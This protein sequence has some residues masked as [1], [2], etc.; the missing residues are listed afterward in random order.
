MFIDLNVTC[1]ALC[2]ARDMRNVAAYY[3]V[4]KR[5]DAMAVAVAKFLDTEAEKLEKETI[6]ELKNANPTPR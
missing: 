2:R 5:G 3:K 1:A 4:N 6:N